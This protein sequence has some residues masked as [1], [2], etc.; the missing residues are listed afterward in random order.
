MKVMDKY[1]H[2]LA[3]LDRAVQWHS[4]LLMVCGVSCKEWVFRR[5][6]QH[7]HEHSQPLTHVNNPTELTAVFLSNISQNT[8]TGPVAWTVAI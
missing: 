1:H 2:V 3:V 7:F 8:I 4:H 6:G 5:E